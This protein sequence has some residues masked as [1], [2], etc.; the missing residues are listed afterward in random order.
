MKA[1]HDEP[2]SQKSIFDKF[3]ASKKE[4]FI[5]YI[6][7]FKCD[8][9]TYHFMGNLSGTQKLDNIDG[10]LIFILFQGSIFRFHK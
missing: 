9:V 6:P 8:V 3:W 7:I 5:S 1:N 4:P 2:W 10:F